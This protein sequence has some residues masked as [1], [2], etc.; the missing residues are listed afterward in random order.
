MFTVFRAILIVLTFLKYG[1]VGGF[2]RVILSIV[3]I[4]TFIVLFFGIVQP[5]V[6]TWI[7]L[8]VSSYVMEIVLDYMNANFSLTDFP[9]AYE[10]SGVAAYLFTSLGLAQ[11]ISIVMTAS[12]IRFALSLSIFRGK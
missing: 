12:T 6:L 2:A 4:K 3:A 11:A 7:M 8:K 1:V 9:V 10:L 5:I